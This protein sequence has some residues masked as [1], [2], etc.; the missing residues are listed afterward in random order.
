MDNSRDWDTHIHDRKATLQLIFQINLDRTCNES[1]PCLDDRV[2]DLRLL[3]AELEIHIRA[4][5]LMIHQVFYSITDVL[6]NDYKHAL[7]PL[8]VTIALIKSETWYTY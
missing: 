6:D 2:H 7:I 4:S 1:R 8:I 5:R 3:I